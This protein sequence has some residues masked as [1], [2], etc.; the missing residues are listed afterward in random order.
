MSEAPTAIPTPR[1]APRGTPWQRL[2]AALLGGLARFLIA[3]PEAPVNALGEAAGELW[4]RFASRRAERARRNYRRVAAHL[5][6]RG[7]ANPATIAA[8]ADPAALERLVR[9]AFH[10]AVRYYLD[11]VRLPGRSQAELGARLVVE[12]PATVEDAFGRAG[13]M[14]FT[15]MHFG[16]VEFPALF[17]VA[18]AGGRVTAPMETLRDPELQAWIE[19]TRSSVGVDLVGLRDARRVLTARLDEG[20]VVGMVADRN[21]AGGTV[22]VPFFGALAPLPMG[23]A[24]LA[25]DRGLPIWF[26]AVRRGPG[27]RY[28]GQLR[29]VDMPTEGNRR[30][31]LT[32]G[33][34]ALARA[35]EE[36]IAV[37]QEQWWSA[38]FPIWPDLDPEARTGTGHLEP[39]A[40]G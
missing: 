9:R 13:P 5:V 29:R 36:A 24:L 15:S 23:P 7:I 39:E 38:F 8:A 17:A 25:M 40:A 6:A 27:R 10:Q 32:G 1:P 35:M 4:Y 14:I 22:D 30:A 12:T 16:A 21:V 19:R 18:R 2:R 11:M 28:Y 26:A 3:V 33:M 31:K 34:T 20:G 37:A